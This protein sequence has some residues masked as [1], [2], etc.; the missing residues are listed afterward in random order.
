MFKR[1]KPR[2]NYRKGAKGKQRFV[3]IRRFLVVFNVIV[4]IAALLATSCLVILAYDVITQCDYFKAQNLKIAGMQRLS[5]KEIAQQE[6]LQII[7]EEIDRVAHILRQL[8]TFMEE[9]VCGNE[10]VDVN[11][12][13]SDLSKITKESFLEQAS[14]LLRLDLQ[15]A[16]PEVMAE[17]NGLKQVLINLVKNAVEAMD[18]EGGLSI[19]TCRAGAVSTL[20]GTSA[21]C[22]PAG[23]PPAA[24]KE[25]QPCQ[26]RTGR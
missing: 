25:A 4:G 19:K 16:V 20:A 6:E 18:G 21:D 9:D 23:S 10:A 7:S 5:E 3:F 17:K 1:K 11:A 24:G 12:L 2:K 8:A 13:L 15:P 14:I 22:D 26:E